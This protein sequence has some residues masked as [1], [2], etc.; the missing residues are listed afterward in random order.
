MKERIFKV[1]NNKIL[2][3]SF[4]LMSLKHI[5]GE[6]DFKIKKYDFAFIGHLRNE[7]GIDLLIEAWKLFIIE[8]PAAKLL[9]AGNLPYHIDFLKDLEKYNVTLDLKYL[10]DKKYFDYIN[11]TNTIVLP[12][13]EGTNSGVVYNLFDL[14]VNIIYSNLPMFDEN[15]LLDK[16]GIFE[17][18]NVRELVKK[19]RLFYDQ[20]LVINH[21]TANYKKK[22]DI[23]V[24]NAYS[25]FLC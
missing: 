8:Y 12:Y 18:G 6:P 21:D 1:S 17:A 2:F 5:F 3:H 7:K 14:N 20:K 16:L 4:P 11:A 25:K 23:E 9:I 19:F 15:Q 22:F 13:R 24:F 10:S